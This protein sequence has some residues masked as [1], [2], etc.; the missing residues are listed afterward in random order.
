MSA[1]RSLP[2]SPSLEQLRNQAKDILQAYRAGEPDAVEE[3]SAHPRSIPPPKAKLTDAQ[4]VLS[5]SYEYDS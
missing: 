2:R 4:L 5:R 3:F 1:R